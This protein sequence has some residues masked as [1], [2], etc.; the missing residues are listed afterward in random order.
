MSDNPESQPITITDLLDDAGHFAEEV[1]QE[2]SDIIQAAKDRG[3]YYSFEDF[4]EY[5]NTLIQFYISEKDYQT[6]LRYK[7]VYSASR[8]LNMSKRIHDLVKDGKDITDIENLDEFFIHLFCIGLERGVL[9][10]LTEPFVGDDFDYLVSLLHQKKAREGMDKRWSHK[11]EEEKE[12]EALYEPVRAYARKE[13][14]N[15]ATLLHN[16]M[17]LKIQGKQEFK[18]LE[19]DKIRKEVKKIAHDYGKVK[20]VPGSRVR[21]P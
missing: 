17:A 19:L 8:V 2:N 15:G 12:D 13:Y 11:R 1:L 20:G 4:T 14:D 6:V 7:K 16:E 10:T 3:K 21:N 18:D 9:S 5:I